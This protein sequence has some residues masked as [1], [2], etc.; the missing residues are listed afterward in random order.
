M[1]DIQRRP[2]PVLAVSRFAEQAFG[3]ET[4]QLFGRVTA[5]AGLPK[6]S[7]VVSIMGHSQGIW[8]LPQQTQLRCGLSAPL[9]AVRFTGTRT[10]YFLVLFLFRRS[11]I[12]HRS[13]L[14]NTGAFLAHILAART[15][16]PGRVVSNAPGPIDLGAGA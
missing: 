3:H 15:R 10:N 16:V 9:P 14:F 2:R 8:A 7:G 12:F 13:F 11:V 4:G 5:M 1:G 6:T